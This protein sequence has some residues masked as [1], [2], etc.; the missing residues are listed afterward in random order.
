MEHEIWWFAKS[1]HDTKLYDFI[2]FILTC[3][4]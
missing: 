1:V 4:C 2:I 3:I